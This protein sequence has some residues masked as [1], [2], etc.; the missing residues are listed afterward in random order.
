MDNPYGIKGL[1]KEWVHKI[2]SSKISPSEVKED[3][4][5]MI[6]MI[7]KYEEDI[8]ESKI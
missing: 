8:K 7:S 1:P 3:P 2:D 4:D 5:G 6:Q